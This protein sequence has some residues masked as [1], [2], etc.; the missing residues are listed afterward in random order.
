MSKP[1]SRDLANM[2]DEDFRLLK[3][4]RRILTCEILS[5]VPL[6]D[7]I[8][9]FAALLETQKAI[10][11]VC[12]VSSLSESP[13]SGLSPTGYSPSGS[14]SIGYSLSSSSSTDHSVHSPPLNFLSID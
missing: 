6:V 13:L 3:C 11:K 4:V 7:T 12:S 14:S 1:V 8:V 2:C 9:V 5:Q 10:V